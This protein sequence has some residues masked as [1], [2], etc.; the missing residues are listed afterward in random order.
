MKRVPD[1]LYDKKFQTVIVGII[2]MT[3]VRLLPFLADLEVDILK[4]VGLFISLIFAQ[5]VSDINKGG[6]K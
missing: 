1:L 6:D 4:I 2:L 3:L 5:G